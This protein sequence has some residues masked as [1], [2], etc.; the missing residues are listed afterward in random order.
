M[1][2]SGWRSKVFAHFR[3]VVLHL[4][5]LESE[6]IG[7]ES[8]II[9]DTAGAGA[10]VPEV[11][12]KGSLGLAGNDP[13]RSPDHAALTA[14]LEDLLVFHTQFLGRRRTHQNRVVPGEQGD[15]PGGLLQPAI[16]RETPTSQQRVRTHCKL[17][18][19]LIQNCAG[20]S[21][22]LQG[23]TKTDFF[24]RKVRFPLPI[25]RAGRFARTVRSCPTVTDDLPMSA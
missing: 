23:A 8:D 16:V 5:A 24:F 21:G 25:R 10:A 6:R 20:A 11:N 1:Q 9:A 7:I 3:S 2:A 17:E 22:Q 4:S 12:D 14:Q 18:T 13:D 19:L 15:R